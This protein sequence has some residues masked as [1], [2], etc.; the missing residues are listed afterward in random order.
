LLGVQV[1]EMSGSAPGRRSGPTSDDT[2]GSTPYATSDSTSDSTSDLRSRD[3]PGRTT[4]DGSPWSGEAPVLVGTEAVLHRVRRAAAVAFLDIDLHLLA[5]RLSAT[6]ET[7]ALLVRAGRL[8]GPRGNGNGSGSVPGSRLA[9]VQVQ[10]RV[11]DHPALE[12]AVRGEPAL[13][14]AEETAIRRLAGLPPFSA[15]ALVSGA[16]APAY[17]A[18]LAEEAG[19]T[20]DAVSVT[21]AGE[22]SW[23]VRAPDHNRLCDFL[24][25]VE[26]PPGRG[27][28]VAVDPPSV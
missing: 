2:P 7:L 21:N 18:A 27:L 16:Q 15:L 22:G 28:R 8:V 26:R 1:D 9:R 25:R 19:P 20:G 17:A 4:G 10:T 5:P 6:E 3:T 23:L 12:A 11:P 14:L 24:A 13:V